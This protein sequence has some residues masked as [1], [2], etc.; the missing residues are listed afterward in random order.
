M[1]S[2]KLDIFCYPKCKWHRA[3]RAVVLTQYRRVTDGRTD[4]RT[5][6]QTDGIAV[7]STALKMR[8]AVKT[9]QFTTNC[10]GDRVTALKQQISL[11]LDFMYIVKHALT[12]EVMPKIGGCEILNALLLLLK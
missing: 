2:T 6:G 3:I 7:A 10:K 8:R 9:G 5:Y 4:G 12:S 11:W 1:V